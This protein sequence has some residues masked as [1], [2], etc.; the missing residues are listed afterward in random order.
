M[1]GGPKLLRWEPRGPPGKK[2]ARKCRWGGYKQGVAS[3][4][5]VGI[6]DIDLA[7]SPRNEWGGSLDEHTM[8]QYNT[9][10]TNV[11]F[12]VLHTVTTNATDAHPCL[13]SP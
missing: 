2:S 10:Q 4:L 13:P 12:N 7:C 3:T 8:G 1:F 11:L 6:H 5:G 9:G